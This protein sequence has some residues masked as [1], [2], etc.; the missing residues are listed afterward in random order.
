MREPWRIGL[1]GAGLAAALAGLVGWEGR[2]RATGRE[3]ALPVVG[4]DPR[5]LLTGHYA[6]LEVVTPL[7][8]AAPCPPG[9]EA[10]VPEGSFDEGPQGWVA[11]QPTSGGW[12]VAGAAPDRTNA[13]RLGPVTMRGTARCFPTARGTAVA[14]DVGIRRFHA[15][16]REAE[17][18]EA[19]LRDGA[20]GPPRAY[21][22][23]S[24]GRDGRARLKGLAVDGR[25]V[26][27]DWF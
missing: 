8:A 25:R 19:L 16:Q 5:G 1:A 4:L 18:L 26:E 23:I 15:G 3:V 11:L 22:L 17:A 27:L 10:G 14:V 6:E 13:R 21:A 9:T 12:S 20:G 7:A 2:A 24:V